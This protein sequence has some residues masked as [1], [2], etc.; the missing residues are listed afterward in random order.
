MSSILVRKACQPILDDA[1]YSMFHCT[2]TGHY[3][4]E[5][6][7][8]TTCGQRFVQIHGVVFSRSNPSIA[9]CDYAAVLLQ[10]WLDRNG[11]AFGDFVDAYTDFHSMKHPERS[12]K[13]LGVNYHCSRYTYC[14]C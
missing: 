7:I 9:E 13:K 6:Y 2:M 1:G 10:K 3:T 5:L 8:F 12:N 4:P 14:S 11:S